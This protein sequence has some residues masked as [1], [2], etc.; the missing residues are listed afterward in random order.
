MQESISSDEN[1]LETVVILPAIVSQSHA[2]DAMREDRGREGEVN[3]RR[4]EGLV[5][6]GIVGLDN[7]Y[8]KI[9]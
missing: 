1:K 2:T 9:L 8:D 3:G 5:I 6:S 7:A 4:R